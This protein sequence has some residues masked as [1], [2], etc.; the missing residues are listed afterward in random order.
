MILLKYNIYLSSLPQSNGWDW[1]I[2]ENNKK[3]A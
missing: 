2:T 3:S 1:E